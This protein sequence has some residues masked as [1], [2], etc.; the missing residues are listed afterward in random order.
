[1]SISTKIIDLLDRNDMT[2]TE[3]DSNN[4]DVSFYSEAGEDFC[5]SVSGD[6]DNAFID[7][8]C[9]YADSFD[10]DEHASMWIDCRGKNGVPESVRELI[11]DAE[12]I[13]NTLEKAALSLVAHKALVLLNQED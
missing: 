7:S 6:N 4:Y 3:F 12:G 8:F 2:I 1:M 11:D 9:Q 13:K 5:F 10:P